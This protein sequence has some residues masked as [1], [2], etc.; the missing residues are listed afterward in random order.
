MTRVVV[1]ASALAA[2][3]FQEPGFEAVAARLDGNTVVA[4]P[5]LKSELANVAV[6]KARRHPRQAARLFAALDVAL[7]DRAGGRDCRARGR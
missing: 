5:R 7:D 1:D 2:V 4:P 6:V 3:I